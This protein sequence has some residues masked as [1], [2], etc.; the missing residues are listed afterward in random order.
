MENNGKKEMEIGNK[1][2]REA[3]QKKEMTLGKKKFKIRNPPPKKRKEHTHTRKQTNKQTNNWR[4]MR[5]YR[6]KNA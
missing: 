1:G 3:K 4:G 2:G 5:K 6:D